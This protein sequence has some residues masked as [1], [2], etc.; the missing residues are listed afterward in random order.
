MLRKDQS[1][2]QPTHVFRSPKVQR[3]AIKFCQFANDAEAKAVSGANDEKRLRKIP[4]RLRNILIAAA[5]LLAGGIVGGT[6]V[7]GLRP[8]PAMASASPI[9]IALAG[10]AVSSTFGDP[11]VTIRGVVKAVYGNSFTVNDSSGQALVRFG[12]K[13]SLSSVLGQATLVTA[14][15]IVTVQGEFEDGSIEARY[16]VTPDGRAWAVGGHHGRRS[17]HHRDRQNGEYITGLT[18][19]PLSN[20]EGAAK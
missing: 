2:H 3:S 6:L 11:I 13:H 12:H 5:L 20:N 8:I 4:R 18:T 14:G 1:G 7:A 19:A 9:T 16:V 15:Q 17:D 10:S